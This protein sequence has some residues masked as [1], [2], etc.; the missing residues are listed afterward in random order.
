MFPDGTPTATLRRR[1]A[2]W[3]ALS[4]LL[5]TH[6]AAIS[7]TMLGAKPLAE[8]C[9]TNKTC[10][11]KRSKLRAA[12]GKPALAATPMCER[13]CNAAVRIGSPQ[14]SAAP[15]A[16]SARCEPPPLLRVTLRAASVA[17][18]P[19]YDPFLFG[20]PPPFLPSLTA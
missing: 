10:C 14:I 19:G 18:T 9:R 2:G 12:D 5:L 8:C 11:C 3:L 15:A 16:G 7:A 1:L 13:R 17:L 6:A 4:L 20:R